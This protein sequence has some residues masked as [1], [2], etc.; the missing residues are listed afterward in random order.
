[1]KNFNAIP[2]RRTV[3]VQLGP[4]SEKEPPKLRMEKWR[5]PTIRST[6]SRDNKDY[7]ILGSILGYP[8]FG[9]LPSS[10]Y[11]GLGVRA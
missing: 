8:S 9:K 6:F 1:M 3:L 4:H 10:C 5:F 7:N 11:Q 2:I